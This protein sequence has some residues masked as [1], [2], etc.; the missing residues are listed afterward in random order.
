[1]GRGRAVGNGGTE[2]RRRLAA[3]YFN[4][5]RPIA[6]GR[7]ARMPGGAGSP[8]RTNSPDSTAEAPRRR[9][10]GLPPLIHCSGARLPGPAHLE[11][12]GD[13]GSTTSWGGASASEALAIADWVVH[14]VADEIERHAETMRRLMM[15]HERARRENRPWDRSEREIRAAASSLPLCRITIGREAPSASG[16]ETWKGNSA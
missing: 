10:A 15:T 12:E 7:M 16:T 9:R 13:F 4:P 11:G 14:R 3:D 8:W 2:I 1:M 6:P 5:D